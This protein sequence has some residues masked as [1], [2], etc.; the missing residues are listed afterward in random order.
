[1]CVWGCGCVGV[2]VGCGVGGVWGCGVCGVGW[3]GESALTN[4]QRIMNYI[5][6]SIQKANVVQD[7]HE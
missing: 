4:K 7:I 6:L 2:C 3:V 1:V 5:P